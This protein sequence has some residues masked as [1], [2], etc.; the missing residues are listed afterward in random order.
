MLQEVARGPIAALTDAQPKAAGL[1]TGYRFRRPQTANEWRYARILVLEGGP[2]AGLRRD[3]SQGWVG[4]YL[5]PP[6]LSRK[7]KRKTG[8]AVE[9]EFFEAPPSTVDATRINSAGYRSARGDVH[10]PF[11]VWGKRVG[12]CLNAFG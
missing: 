6:M 8:G 9:Q 11:S 7:R 10:R 1:G 4:S 12:N 3:D 5:K 2:L